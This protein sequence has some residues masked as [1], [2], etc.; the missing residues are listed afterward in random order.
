[1][2]APVFRSEGQA[3]LLSAVL[4]GSEEISIA[5]AAVRSGVAY[6]TAYAVKSRGVV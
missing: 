4:L 3:R 1:M 6:P 5:D 2:L